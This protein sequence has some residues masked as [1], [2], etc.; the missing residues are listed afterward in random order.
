MTR[1]ILVLALISGVLLPV[2]GLTCTN[3]GEWL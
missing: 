1:K 2:N 3:N